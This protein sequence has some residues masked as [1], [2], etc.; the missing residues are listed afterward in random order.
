MHYAIPM[1]S[2]L[3][4]QTTLHLHRAEVHSCN[5]VTTQ[6]TRDS[7]GTG[8]TL[9]DPAMCW[10]P[11]EI[12]DRDC[13][14]YRP[15]PLRPRAQAPIDL[16]TVCEMIHLKIESLCSGKQKRP[17]LAERFPTLNTASFVQRA[18][19]TSCGRDESFHLAVQIRF[20]KSNPLWSASIKASSMFLL[21]SCFFAMGNSMH[22][23]VASSAWFVLGQ[24]E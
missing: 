2:T 14:R 22:G 4:P 21:D 12:S 5:Y 20:V 16:G 10:S 17:L 19:C 24:Q 11:R 3:R 15:R 18:K 8:M 7:T 23:N 6:M 13:A 9:T 1:P